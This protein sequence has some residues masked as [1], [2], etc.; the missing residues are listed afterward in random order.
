[1]YRRYDKIVCDNT[2]KVPLDLPCTGNMETHRVMRLYWPS[3]TP[4]IYEGPVSNCRGESL[5]PCCP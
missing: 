4:I 1:M 3:P 2:F 5:C